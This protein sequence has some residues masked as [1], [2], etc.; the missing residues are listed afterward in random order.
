MNNFKITFVGQPVGALGILQT[1]TRVVRAADAESARLK[2]YD[3]FQ[4]ITVQGPIVTTDAA[5][6]FFGAQTGPASV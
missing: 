6:D 2:L 3:N 1:F 4:H 5:L